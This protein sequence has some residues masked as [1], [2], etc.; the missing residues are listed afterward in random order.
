[1]FARFR[2]LGQIFGIARLGV[3]LLLVPGYVWGQGGV[4]EI[5]GAVDA[6]SDPAQRRVAVD[7]I[8][9]WQQEQ[10]A[11]GSARARALD[12]PVRVE[13]RDGTVKEVT[14]LDEAGNLLYLV[15]HNDMAAISTGA[16]VL[17]QTPYT[18]SGTNVVIGMW[19][20]GAGRSTHREFEGTRMVIRDGSTP[21]THA[22][23][24]GGT[25]AAAGITARAK[26]MAYAARVDSY[27]WNDDKAEMTARAA[28]GPG[29]PESLLLS[30]HSYGI[31]SGWFLTG[32]SNPAYIWYGSGT[33]ASDIDPRFGQ[34]NTFARDSDALA[35]QAPY[36]LMFR[37][38]GNDRTDNPAAGQVVQLSPSSST[39]VAYDSTL[40]PAGDG[41]YR[42]GY[43]TIG[44]DAI[45]KNVI[46][47]G[48]VSDAVSGGVRAPGQ[49]LVS[50]FSSWG[51]TD[52]GRIKPDL[53]ANGAGL[54]STLNGGDASYGTM[55]GTSM[56]SPNAAGTAALLVEKYARL[57]A[58]GAMRASTLKGLLIHTA[59][60]LGT[61]GP[62]YQYGWGL[63]NSVTAAD[64]L[65]DHA[66]RPERMRLQEDVLTTS[67]PSRSYSFVW[68]GVSPIRATLSWTDPAGTA[69]TSSDLRSPRLRN[70]LDLRIVGPDNTVYL[71]YVMPFVGT[72]TVASMSAAATNGVNNTDTIEQVYLAVPPAAGVYVVTV[73]HQGS[74]TDNRQVFSLLLDGAS[75]EEPP[76]PPLQVQSVSPTV[77]FAGGV[78]TLTL[79]GT[80]LSQATDLRLARAGESDIAATSLRLQG[81]A[82]VGEVD[83]TGASAGAWDVV[84]ASESER[85]TLAAGFTV[86][87]A[88]WS[89]NFDGA[90][91]GWASQVL[92]NRGSNAW[93]LSDALAHTRPY[94]RFA[95]APAT[96]SDTVLVSPPISIPMGA[97]NLQL[98][99]WHAWNLEHRQDGGRLEIQ[100]NDGPWIG[101]GESG[102]GTQFASR[103]YTAEIRG[104]G[105]PAERSSFAVKDAWTGD[106]GGFVETIVSLVDS[107]QFAG[108]AVRFR[109]YLAT[110]NSNASPGWYVDSIVLLGDGDMLNQPPEIVEP[111]GV[112]GAEILVESE[113]TI[114][115]VS[116]GAAA[117]TVL[118]TD[119]G[120]DQNLTYS[121]TATG[122]APVFFLPNHSVDANQTVAYF[123]ALGDYMVQVAVTDADGLSVTDAAMLRILSTPTSIKIDPGTVTLRV[124]EQVQFGATLRDQ[125]N[126]PM[127]AQPTAFDWT[128]TG[129]GQIDQNG[130]FRAQSVGENFSVT[131]SLEAFSE[132]IIL[133]ATGESETGTSGAAQVTVLQGVAEVALYAVK[134][135]YDG[136][137]K[138]VGVETTPGGLSVSVTYNETETLPALPGEYQ[139]MAIVTDESYVG[140]TNGVFTIA[141]DREAFDAWAASYGLTGAESEPDADPDGNGLS[142]LYKWRFGLDPTDPFA[143]LHVALEREAGQLYLVVSRVIPEGVF[144]ILRRDHLK[145]DWRVEM[146]LR[147]GQA[148]DGFRIG[149]DDAGFMGFLRI[150]F[151]LD[152]TGF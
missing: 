1:M 146:A 132:T 49:A 83:L 70:N 58:G 121:W 128:V 140:G 54:Y 144:T 112:E 99:F 86:Q 105:K 113:Q 102:S 74:L 34:Y 115:A 29:D 67:E 48:S 117:L 77:A 27:D 44:F 46:T 98:H 145:E 45:A 2:Q 127:E 109:W 108:H 141:Y 133:V 68:D 89:E 66:A 9:D 95:A 25:L 18:L 150:R 50:N 39:T 65:G 57:F 8:R 101:V 19:D 94:A 4:A 110:D 143:G 12:L 130:L 73:T 22:T 96:L 72:W 82:L 107:G 123:E 76:P 84:V 16:N 93:A 126:D 124:E 116:A 60:D 13:R 71:P 136:M 7:A 106:S 63:I 38:A 3:L 97:D 134:A 26:G 59:D 14:G 5:L 62:N 92:N 80:A 147:P 32:G 17:Y 31:I 55:S 15:T 139:V 78:V 148:A 91:S 52:D 61:P 129:G 11:A 37:S 53:V 69:T 64:L 40:H 21:I 149:I 135:L 81:D 114:Q 118:A 51:P 111:I 56:S 79:E 20:G 43:D 87:D 88:L 28:T 100:V 120:G 47:I 24:V 122:P 33:T 42:G 30:N 104:T 36:Y 90:F 75:G 35:Y 142:N 125:F 119:D 137:P 131:A 85:A 10:R 23:H 138:A 6:F 103:G 41:V 151:V 152:Y